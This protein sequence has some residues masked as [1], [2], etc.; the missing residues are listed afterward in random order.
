ME[1][2]I[3]CSKKSRCA[4]FNFRQSRHQK[5]EVYQ[6]KRE[7]FSVACQR[8]SQ[9]SKTETLPS[10]EPD[11]FDSVSMVLTVFYEAEPDA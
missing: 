2:N 10:P 5:E 9:D 11:F 7:Y 1:E 8:Q 6:G 3:P 4:S